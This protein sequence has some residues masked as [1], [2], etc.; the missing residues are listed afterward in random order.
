VGKDRENVSSVIG[1]KLA[2][3]KANRSQKSTLALR[4]RAPM[5]RI[6]Q[7]VEIVRAAKLRFIGLFLF[8]RKTDK[9]R[10]INEKAIVSNTIEAFMTMI[11]CTA[12]GSSSYVSSGSCGGLR[13]RGYCRRGIQEEHDFSPGTNMA[14]SVLKYKSCIVRLSD[15]TTD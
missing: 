12:I 7:P 8:D 11:S 5:P 10:T 3:A 1:M 9:A 15:L 2:L 6:Q 14:F 13:C 4:F